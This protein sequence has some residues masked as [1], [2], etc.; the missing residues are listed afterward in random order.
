[1][2]RTPKTRPNGAR[3]SNVASHSYSP[4]TGQLTVTFHSGRRYTY[5]G[6]SK[7]RAA[8]FERA[9]RARAAICIATSSASTTVRNASRNGA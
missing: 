3:S 7:D 9:R 5:A 4:E 2:A 6:V 8:D 1:M